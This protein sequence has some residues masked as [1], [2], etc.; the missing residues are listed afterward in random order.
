MLHKINWESQ[1]GRRLR[2]RD[3][4][5]FATVVERGSMAVRHQ[6]F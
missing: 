3:L 2:L 1:I 6:S 4:H 5:V